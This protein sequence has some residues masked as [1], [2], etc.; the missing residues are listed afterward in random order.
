MRIDTHNLF[1]PV[2]Y[3]NFISVGTE[4]LNKLCANGLSWVR[5]HWH[6]PEV[7]GEFLWVVSELA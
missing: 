6:P 2:P 5:N 3:S 1:I 7:V 4:R